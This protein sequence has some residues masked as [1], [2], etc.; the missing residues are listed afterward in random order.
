MLRNLKSRPEAFQNNY[1]LKPKGCLSI[2]RAQIT[3]PTGREADL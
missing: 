2:N 1:F 3:G